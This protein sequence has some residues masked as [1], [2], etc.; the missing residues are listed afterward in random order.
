MNDTISSV[1]AECDKHFDVG[2]RD[3]EEL[4]NEL[5][6]NQDRYIPRPSMGVVNLVGEASPLMQLQKLVNNSL[7]DQKENFSEFNNFLAE[8]VGIEIA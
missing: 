5:E 3:L 8:L 7:F 2:V 4:C 6:S 1:I